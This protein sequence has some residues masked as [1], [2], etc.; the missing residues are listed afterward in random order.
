MLCQLEYV[1]KSWLVDSIF[2]AN[3]AMARDVFFT[4]IVISWGRY[5]FHISK[6]SQI[7]VTNSKPHIPIRMLEDCTPSPQFHMTDV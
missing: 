4:F 3:F 6:H 2:F 1:T 5:L 7:R